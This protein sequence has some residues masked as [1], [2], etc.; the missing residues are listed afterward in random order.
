MQIL[1]YT[2]RMARILHIGQKVE[3]SQA[4]ESAIVRKELQ[5]SRDRSEIIYLSIY[6]SILSIYLSIYL[7]GLHVKS[8]ADKDTA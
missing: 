8:A 2:V 7:S 5:V 6:L 3:N 1:I 4:F